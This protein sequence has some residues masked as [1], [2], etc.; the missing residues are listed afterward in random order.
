MLL[1]TGVYSEISFGFSNRSARR[2]SW[3]L[4]ALQ[5]YGDQGAV[6]SAGHSDSGRCAGT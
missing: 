5:E 6:H 2:F 1:R 4:W 3:L